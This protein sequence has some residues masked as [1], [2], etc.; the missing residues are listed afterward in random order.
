MMANPQCCPAKPAAASNKDKPIR[1]RVG[2]IV[3]GPMKPRKILTRPVNPMK[4]YR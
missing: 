3:R 1:Q 4:I 2:A